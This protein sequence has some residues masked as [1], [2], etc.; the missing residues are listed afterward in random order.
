M[1]AQRGTGVKARKLGK[2][3]K[4]FKQD[5]S[6]QSVD[7]KQRTALTFKDKHMLETLPAKM[8][9][10]QGKIERLQK[11]LADPDLFARDPDIFNKAAKALEAQELLLEKAEERWLE[12]E[13]LQEELGES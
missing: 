12:L 6:R 8:E 1:V 13:I 3:D 10:I 5:S 2:K 11:R 4:A 7:F 9:E